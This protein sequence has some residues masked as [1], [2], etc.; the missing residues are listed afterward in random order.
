MVTAGG[1][2]SYQGLP[3]EGTLGPDP[4]HPTCV[5][6]CAPGLGDA[7]TSASDADAS[8]IKPAEAG[9]CGSGPPSACNG[10]ANIG[11]VVIATCVAG[12]PPPMSGG[13]IA[14]GTYAMV[15][16]TAYASSCAGLSLPTGGPTTMLITAGCMQSVDV[17]GGAKTYSFV[18]SGSTLSLVEL[19]P[20]ASSTA[21]QYSATA[22]SYSELAPF[23]PGINVVSVFQ[24][25]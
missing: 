25:Q 10:L 14:D 2:F 18:T 3:C 7:G 1:G 4:G 12:A 9:P 11:R 20:G 17:S 15:S 6:D 21:M 8:T 24:K 22:T 5:C 23:S 13:A 16:A 19:C